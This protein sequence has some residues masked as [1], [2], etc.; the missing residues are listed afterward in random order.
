[1]KPVASDTPRAWTVE[2]VRG[3]WSKSMAS[4]GQAFSQLAAEDAV[5]DV[6]ERGLGDGVGERDVGGAP[7]AH[8][9]FERVGDLDR[10]GVLAQPAADAVRSSST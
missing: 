1:M 3:S 5:V 2:V 6:D 10:A 8:A 9:A 7:R 4:V